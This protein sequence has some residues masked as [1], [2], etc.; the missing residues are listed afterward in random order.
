MPESPRLEPSDVGESPF[1][2]QTS[3][4][5][6]YTIERLLG[7]GGMA[8][9]HLAEERK[10]RREV[11]IKV[12]RQE[13][14]ASVG[15]ERFLREIGIAARLSH[16]HIV[17][18]I[19]SGESGGSLYYVSPFIPGG[20]LRD[21]LNR[22]KRLG[23]DD[24]LRIA[25][26]IGAGLDYAH[27]NGFVHRDVKPENILFADD[28]A[29]LSDFGIAYVQTTEE[30]EPLTLDG[31]ALG[32]PEYMSPEQAAGEKSVG[33]A[34]DVYSLAC[35]IYEM[36]AGEP[37]FKGATPRATMAK[38][39][40]QRARPLRAL[41][42]DAPAGFDRVMEKALTKDPTQR[43]QSVV[44]FCD[45][46]TRARSEPNRPFMMTSRSIAVLPFVNA[47]PDPDNEY[48]SDGIT[49]ELINALAK[50]DGLRVAS[51]TSVFALKGKAQDVRA[52]GALL[53]ASEVLEGTVRR[54]VDNL[55]ITVQ[56]TSTDDGRLMWS[57]RYDRRLD[58]VFAIQDEIA[59]TIVTTLRSTSFADLAPA[60][61]NRH[62]ENIQAYGL[63]LRGR[64]AWNK[65]T[66]EGVIEGI[67]FFEEAIALDPRYALA[68]TGLADSYS[69]HID[70]RNV[71]VHEG[72]EK[73]KFYARKA[74]E[75]D[76][77]LAEAH[78]SL[79]WSLF[80]YDWRWD[81]AAREFRRAIELDPRYAPA[82]QWYALILASQGH[83]DE[84]LI[85]SHTAQENDPASVSVRRS[86]GYCYLYARKYDQARYHLD[87]AV[88]MNPT[89][90]ES[91]RI[92]GLILTLQR[93]YPAA[94]RVLREGLALAPECAN[95]TRATLAYSLGL[96]GDKSFAKQVYEDLMERI[97]T[98][99]V[100]PVDMV[101]VTLGL[102]DYQKA[103]DW[104]DRAIDERRGWPAYLR[105]HPVVDPLRDDP[106]FPELV[107]KMMF[108]R[109][110]APPVVI[111]A[112]SRAAGA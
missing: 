29:M 55:R 7:S 99:Y 101:L 52:I 16:P 5:D 37:P 108:D 23:V 34:G 45:A 36:L 41:R 58:D 35:V 67:K 42:P 102:G 82:H 3:L 98:D 109:P 68:Y 39:V 79:A 11:A 72:H 106:R 47:S 107:K 66:S 95:T 83:F 93:D 44:E 15:K 21:K 92:A 65:R 19:D 48:L 60:A 73:A 6:R 43:Y 9:V 51:R 103:L 20:S 77:S 97:K 64:Y 54:S 4:A 78:A 80:I 40:T 50:V 33:V 90:E 57:E 91:Y 89:A 27:R 53:E 112:S 31:L 84:A 100:S 61:A 49:D 26:E 2:L 32:T 1:T 76:E 13:F 63:Y 22:E 38:Q 86:L 71:P 104:V 111:P 59:R 94:E 69:L 70:Y 105:V 87:R 28:H 75:L 46:L 10:H 88:A 8:T 110:A 62:T 17:P 56:L 96:A 81:E 25:H 85:E 30:G 12:L 14:S 24:A 18:L 74:I